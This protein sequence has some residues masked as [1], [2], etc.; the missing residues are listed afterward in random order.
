MHK[1]RHLVSMNS[2]FRFLP[3]AVILLASISITSI[4]SDIITSTK[5]RQASYV[6]GI[7][8][9]IV[10]TRSDMGQNLVL[11]GQSGGKKGA[12]G[13]VVLARNDGDSG[14]SN[15][16]LEDAANKDGDVI[17]YGKNIVIPG[18]DGH[19]VLADSRNNNGH[20][21]QN[22]GYPPFNPMI[23]WL[24]YLTSRSDASNNYMLSILGSFPTAQFYG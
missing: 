15:F 1:I 2:K 18:K 3:S 7:E 8:A 14:S 4:I 23:L 16:V 19:I 6:T 20:H 5:Q 22:R 13:N 17:M 10:L 21:D 24:P 9:H 12:G 11:S